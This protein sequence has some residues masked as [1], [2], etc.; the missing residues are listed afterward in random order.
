MNNID[1]FSL[2]FLGLTGTGHCIG[3]CG[4]LVVAIPGRTQRFSAHL[5][6]HLGRTI[7][8][9][10]IGAL[11]GGL[12]SGIA[13]LALKIGSDPLLVFA[14]IQVVFSMVA[15]GFLFWFGLSRLGFTQEPSWMSSASPDMAPGYQ[16]ILQWAFVQKRMSGIFLIGLMMGLLPCGLSFAAF[17]RA[18]AAQGTLEGGLL[19][20]AFAL[21][22]LP[23]LLLIGTG[24]SRLFRRY[25]KHSEI[26][27]GILMIGM[28]FSVAADA[29][30]AIFV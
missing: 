5:F 15:A 28:G 14:K 29:L 23:G 2:F 10:F 9:S 7:T 30:F 21:G 6:Y 25:R 27:S 17:A 11:M 8:Y 1:I 12:G 4:P 19:L 16:K 20:L 26:I 13:S 24:A 18:L 22:T 3:M